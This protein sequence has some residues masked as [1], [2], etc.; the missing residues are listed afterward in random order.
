[1]RNRGDKVA[2]WAWGLIIIIRGEEGAYQDH[3]RRD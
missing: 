1:M 3:G 2:I